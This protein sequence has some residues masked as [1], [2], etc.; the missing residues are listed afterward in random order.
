[1]LGL[2]TETV[3]RLIVFSIV[4]VILLLVEQLVPARHRSYGTR[5][6][7]NL[8]LQL[9]NIGLTLA[10]PISLSAAALF[11]VYE[12]AGLFNSAL[13]AYGLWTKIIISWLVI[14]LVMYWLHRA[15]HGVGFL[16]RIHR[17]HHCDQAVDVTTTFRTHPFE[18]L[19][20]VC[21]RAGTIVLL[22]M[23]L[24]GVIIYEILVACMATFIHANVRIH[25]DLDRGLRWLFVTPKMHLIHHGRQIADYNSN[26]GL[27]LSIWD[28]LFG[29]YR[30]E[31]VEQSG[32]RCG[33]QDLS[34]KHF[35]GLLPLLM[36]PLKTV[37]KYK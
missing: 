18:I 26:Y 35:Q 10:L 4:L 16:W 30:H 25:S 6:I 32:M 22:G 24:L 37:D 23:P 7:S 11:A 34:A 27:V 14:D 31:S 20:T 36:L 17:V 19:I 9:V 2:E 33:L 13:S 8:S 1:M 5:L 12:T 21:V 15:Y 29:T 3:Y 28:R